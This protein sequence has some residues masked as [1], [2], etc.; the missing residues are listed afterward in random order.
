MVALLSEIV[1]D[2]Q[3]LA[4]V[5]TFG[6]PIAAIIGGIWY[7]GTKLRSLNDLKRSMVE[8]GMSAD[9]I[10]QVIRAGRKDS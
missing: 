1:W 4:I 7:Q 6:V 8:R 9:E 3:N 5:G 2:A 10:E